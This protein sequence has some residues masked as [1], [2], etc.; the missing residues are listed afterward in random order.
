MEKIL[1]IE[2]YFKRKR[3][4]NCITSK[5]ELAVPGDMGYCGFRFFFRMNQM[6][7][8]WQ[9]F[10]LNC[11]GRGIQKKTVFFLALPA[12]GKSRNSG[13]PGGGQA[14]NSG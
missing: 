8:I 6:L 1:I 13:F 4:G 10:P 7:I 3:E 14:S 12:H 5:P 2:P 11:K 9:Y